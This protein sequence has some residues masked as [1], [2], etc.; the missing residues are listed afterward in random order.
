MHKIV[1]KFT[2]LKDI[3]YISHLDTMRMFQRAARRAEIPIKYSEGFNPHPKISFAYPLSLGIESIGDYFEMELI[4]KIEE[5]D[6][7]KKFNKTLPE[8]VDI[9]YAEYSNSKDS[10]MALA[11][12]SEYIFNIDL[13]ENIT[14]LDIDNILND[15]IEKGRMITRTRKKKNKIVTKELSTKDLLKHAKLNNYG[16]KK[17][18]IETILKTSNSGSLKTDEFINLLN[19]SGLKI[20]YY[21]VIRNNILDKNMKPLLEIK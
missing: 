8:G 17:V 18:C 14:E 3:K 16:N 12:W 2:K 11:V 7:I 9:L 4:D 13:G 19:E 21:E 15:I 6:F 5:N 1:G 20:D 10:L